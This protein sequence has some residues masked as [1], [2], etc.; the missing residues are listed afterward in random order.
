MVNRYIFFLFVFFIPFN[1]M[2]G[3]DNYLIGAR[4]D[5]MGNATVM[6]PDLW[7]LSHN[8]AGLGW[9]RSL[10]AGFHFEN[11]FVV[12]EYSL[13]AAGL[14]IPVKPGTLGCMVYYFGYS[15]YHETRAALAFGRAFTD[16]FAVGIQL[17]YMSTYVADGYGSY[18]AVVVEGGMI[19]SPLKNIYIGA[20][21]FNPTQAHL[22]NLVQ[23]VIP[24]NLRVGMGIQLLD[25][26]FVSV[27]S[28]TSNQSKP[29]YKAGM[30]INTASNLFFRAGY[31]TDPGR[32]SFGLGYL[33]RGL[34][35]DLAF[36]LH[37]RLGFT[38]YFS[39]MYSF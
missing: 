26:I 10:S 33:F 16:K 38:P 18:G 2:A 4:F 8:Q 1:V 21:I 17:N 22:N 15:Q 19:I 29:V 12:P 7:S 13:S 35:G 30:E 5:G 28:E 37:P 31:S 23:D 6:I 20:H 14:A 3:P 34:R 27:E 25:Q 11:K 24:T 36:T 39:L 32:P 9:V